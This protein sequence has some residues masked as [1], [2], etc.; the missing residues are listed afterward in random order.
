MGRHVPRD[1]IIPSI[2]LRL[3][4]IICKWGRNTGNDIRWP[5]YDELPHWRRDTQR[6]NR[7]FPLWA[8]FFG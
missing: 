1:R 4:P 5:V 3:P 2:P 8:G 7:R 6:G